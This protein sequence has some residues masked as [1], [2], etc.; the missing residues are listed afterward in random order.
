MPHKWGANRST[1]F[2]KNKGVPKIWWFIIMIG[3]LN[4]S[5]AGYIPKVY[6]A[7]RLVSLSLVLLSL[8]QTRS[9]LGNTDGAS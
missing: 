7:S 3:N 8:C 5:L 9:G 2:E 1:S 4:L 6:P